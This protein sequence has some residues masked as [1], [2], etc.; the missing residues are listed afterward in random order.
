MAVRRA[1]GKKS[2]AISDRS[3]FKVPYRS[4]KTTWDGLRVEPEEYEPKHPQ[5]TPARNVVDATALFD[6]RPDNDPENVEI[7]YGFTFDPFADRSSRPPVGIPAF[8]SIGHINVA[9]D[10]NASVTG[11]A[12]TTALGAF[13][14]FISLDALVT[15]VAGTG[16]IGSLG[17]DVDETIIPTGV[18]G[19]GAIGT[20]TRGGWTNVEDSQTPNWI[21]IDTAA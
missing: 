14:L 9:F 3:G 12:G 19:T 8:G 7:K 5:L 20:I 10:S 4:L 11:L 13:S 17:T 2:V 21:D 16:A 15:G 6:P 18:A 1:K